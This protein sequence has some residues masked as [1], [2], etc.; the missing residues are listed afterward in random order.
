VAPR[1][2]AL[3]LAVLA[4]ATPAAAGAPAPGPDFPI[5][6]SSLALAAPQEVP[7]PPAAPFEVVRRAPAPARS[8]RL[9]LYTALAGAALVGA[10]FPLSAE[11]DRRYERY[12]VE[13]DPGRMEDHFRGAERMDRWST[14]ALLTGEALLATAVWLRFVRGSPHERVAL[15]VRPARCALALRF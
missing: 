9:A 3:V 8:H 10:S 1:L 2:A 11:A 14:A 4:G 5:G 7:A 6:A 15:E 12:L 13:V